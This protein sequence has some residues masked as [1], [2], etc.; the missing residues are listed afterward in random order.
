VV[1]HRDGRVRLELRSDGAGHAVTQVA[2][3]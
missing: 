2:V 3:A 1:T